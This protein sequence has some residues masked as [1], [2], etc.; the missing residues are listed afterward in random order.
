MALIVLVV[1]GHV[2]EGSWGVRVGMRAYRG[3]RNS[4]LGLR[5]YRGPDSRD[6]VYEVQPGGSKP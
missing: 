5:L 1:F 2:V 3:F 4:G 6:S